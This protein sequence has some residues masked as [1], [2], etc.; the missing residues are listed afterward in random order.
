MIREK[1]VLQLAA[2]QS[3]SV[4]ED[5][6]QQE[7]EKQFGY[8][9]NPTPTP[10]PDPTITNTNPVSATVVTADEFQKNYQDAIKRF[11]D[12]H[13]LNEAEF[14]N[15][16]RYQLL[17]QKLQDAAPLDV[18]TTEE[19]VHARHILVRLPEVGADRTQQQAEVE[20]LTK[21]KAIRERIVKGEKFEDVAKEVSDDTSNKDKGGDLDWFGRGQMVK[22]FEDAAFSLEPG[23]LSEPVKTSF[24]Y[25]LIEVIEKDANRPVEESVLKQRRSQAYEE[26]LKAKQDAASIER[27]W[28]SNLV[29]ALPNDI[30]TFLSQ[31]GGVLAQQASQSTATPEAPAS[32]PAA[33]S[34]PG[35]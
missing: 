18:P 28:T 31:V 2:A 16:Y 5:E 13:S 33:T 17:N 1:F 30:Q 27:R 4:T 7:V 35:S 15:L 20:A 14:R 26:W 25:H 34:T 24:G 3:L 23:V 32:T 29:P 6:V 10:T 8:E 19:Q 11:S 21:I 12:S 9:R 22:E